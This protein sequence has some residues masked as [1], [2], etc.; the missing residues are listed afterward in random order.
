MHEKASVPRKN[1]LDSC[2][3][4]QGSKLPLPLRGTTAEL[5][6]CVAWSSNLTSMKGVPQQREM[7]RNMSS[8]SSSISN[9]SGNP[10]GRISMSIS[11][12]LHERMCLCV[13]VCVS[14]CGSGVNV[15]ICVTVGVLVF[16][17]GG[18]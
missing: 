13:R 17:F 12:C 4:R 11:Q 9:L 6:V 15:C 14:V 7:G 2:A 18:F 5:F 10:P 16:I 3:N 8:S 1:G